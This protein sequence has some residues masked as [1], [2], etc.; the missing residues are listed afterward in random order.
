MAWTPRQRW[1]VGS[2]AALLACTIVLTIGI[3][4]SNAELDQKRRRVMELVEME[5]RFIQRPYRL[6]RTSYETAVR[7]RDAVQAGLDRLQTD[8]GSRYRH[9]GTGL[10]GL[11]QFTFKTRLRD[12]AEIM[13]RTLEVRGVGAPTV[14]PV[15][16]FTTY[17]GDEHVF[18]QP[19]QMA[20]VNAQFQIH[21][22]LVAQAA[23]SGI[24]RLDMLRY[25]GDVPMPRPT[26]VSAENEDLYRYHLYDISVVGSVP[27]LQ[28]FLVNL[29]HSDF[30]FIVGFMELG[31]LESRTTAAFAAG[32]PSYIGGAPSPDAQRQVDKSERIIFTDFAPARMNIRVK[33]IEFL[34]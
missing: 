16:P 15:A 20:A 30:C 33:F 34:N 5:K 32:I 6:D 8:L 26:V 19:E 22:E 1:F 9:A 17:F 24:E 18:P 4:R 29:D 11:S 28:T 10:P 3:V 31:S 2:I 25:Q 13:D 23:A 21:D 7:N 14:G 27:S 12:Q